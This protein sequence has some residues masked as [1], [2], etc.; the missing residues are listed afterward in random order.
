MRNIG[1]KNLK[2]NNIEFLCLKMEANPGQSGR[3]YLRELHRYRFGTLGDGSWNSLYLTPRGGYRGM[4]FQDTAPKNRKDSM[5]G[6]PCSSVGQF[7]LTPAGHAV[8]QVA[9][10]KLGLI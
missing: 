3:W 2:L 7:Q 4:L 10:V 1:Q 5:N 6:R 8:A 9:R